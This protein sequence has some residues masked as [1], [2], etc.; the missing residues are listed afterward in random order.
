MRAHRRTCCGLG[1]A[2][3]AGLVCALI[4]APARACDHPSGQNVYKLDH[5]VFGEIGRHVVTF[6]CQ[7]D[8][9]VVET[10]IEGKA[11]LF[12]MPVYTLDASYREIWRGDRLISFDSKINDNGEK[13]EVRAR[14]EG[15]RTVIERRRG[16][17]EAPA[18]IV[19]DHPWNHDVIDR[20]MVFDSRRGKLRHVQVESAGKETLELGGRKVA[21]QRYIIS[22]DLERVVWYGEDGTWLQAELP[23]G[24][25][26]VLVT[27]E[28]P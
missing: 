10:V 28:Q 7:G 21:A 2:L 22:G 18:T 3:V 8:D 1:A 5:E 23:Y 12:D 4:T 27:L 19:S 6:S 20:T 14:A 25:G 26:D 16:S 9:L 13:F 15:D 11:T 17:I 24:G